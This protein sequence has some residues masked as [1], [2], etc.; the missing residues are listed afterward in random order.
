IQTGD[1]GIDQLEYTG[2]SQTNMICTQRQGK[3][4]LQDGAL[5]RPSHTGIGGNDCIILAAFQ[6][7]QNL[8]SEGFNRDVLYLKNA[9]MKLSLRMIFC[10]Q[11]GKKAPF[12]GKKRVAELTGE[13]AKI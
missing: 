3:V 9:S 13:K 6:I 12:S 7:L 1:G 8:S 5:Y 10:Q 2:S 4:L 11:T